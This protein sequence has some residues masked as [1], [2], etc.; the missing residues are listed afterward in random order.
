VPVARFL[1]APAAAKIVRLLASALV[2]ALG[3]YFLR[4]DRLLAGI[5]RV[6]ALTFLEAVGVA[7]VSLIAL[8]A[9]WIYIVRRLAPAPI[10]EQW[11]VYLLGTFVNSFTPAN[12]GGDIYRVMALRPW[13]KDSISTLVAAVTVERLFGLGAFFVGYLL[14]LAG[15]ALTTKGGLASISPSLSYPALPILAILAAASALIFAAHR[16]RWRQLFVRF[17]LVA[18][19]VDRFDQG[20]RLSTKQNIGMLC[21]LSLVAWATWVMATAIV[22]NRLGLHIS[23]AQLALVVTLTELVRLIPIS[24]QGIG[25]REVTFAAL[26]G[27]AGGPPETGFVVAAVAYAALSATLAIAGLAGWGLNL[28]PA[29]PF[30]AR[31]PHSERS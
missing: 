16:T 1:K 7:S 23:V 6:D 19:A 8:G 9:R 13:A 5:S 28:M 10:R 24:F 21:F 2:L 11:R 26:V 22:S 4:W 15:Q 3:L 27:F 20:V 31:E 14:S 18:I 12:I 25:V 17:P 30:V 29:I